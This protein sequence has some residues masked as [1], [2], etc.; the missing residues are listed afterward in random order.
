M[1]ETTEVCFIISRQ[2]DV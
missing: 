1:S 2:N